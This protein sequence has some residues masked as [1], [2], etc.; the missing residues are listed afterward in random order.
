M[1][2]ELCGSEGK[3]YRAEIEGSILNVC[4]KCARFGRVIGA[5][6]EAVVEK[7]AKKKKEIVEVAKAPEEEILE[8]VVP[9]IG[10][11]IKA[12]REE[13]GLEQEDFGK[14]FGLKESIVHKIETGE[15]KPNIEM[16]RKFERALGLKLV[17]EYKESGAGA[18]VATEGLTLGDVLKLKKKIK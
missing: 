17:E 10:K 16:A 15:F 9:D 2:C 3:I 8:V 5:V 18:R 11:R 13:L 4:E 1:R 14:L 7:K 12:K 6:E